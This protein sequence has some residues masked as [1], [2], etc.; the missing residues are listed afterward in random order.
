MH[1]PQEYEINLLS[2]QL[3]ANVNNL[4]LDVKTPNSIITLMDST[5]NVL[6][7]DEK[8]IF[9]GIRHNS[10]LAVL[11]QSSVQLNQLTIPASNQVTIYD[12][13]ITAA[14]EK[15]KVSK[16]TKEL[17]MKHL[18]Q[19]ELQENEWFKENSIL[20]LGVILKN[21]ET[22]APKY[23]DVI[24]AEFGSELKYLTSYLTFN[25]KKGQQHTVERI[26]NLYNVAIYFADISEETKSNQK[27][28]QIHNLISRLTPIEKEK[29]LSKLH[30]IYLENKTIANHD[31]SYKVKNNLKKTILALTSE[32]NQFQT[33]KMFW[34]KKS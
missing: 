19:S 27:L 16:L 20:D 32:R 13:Q 28:E 34:M 10:K 18:L 1:N 23:S 5:G 24:M 33:E 30:Q 21:T 12:F 9:T 17:K 26:L 8:T 25:P 31:L 3:W 7:E 4:K 2:G 22:K 29:L 14:F 6:R 11:D 15:L